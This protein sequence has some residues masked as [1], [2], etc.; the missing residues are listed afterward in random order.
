MELNVDLGLSM[1]RLLSGEW[2]CKCADKTTAMNDAREA[3]YSTS[4]NSVHRPSMLGSQ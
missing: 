1:S 4:I 3:W 2:F